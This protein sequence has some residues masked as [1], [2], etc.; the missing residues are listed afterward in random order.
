MENNDNKRRYPKQYDL[1]MATVDDFI[2]NLNENYTVNNNAYSSGHTRNA[3]DHSSIRHR[4][5]LYWH[6]AFQMQQVNAASHNGSQN[7]S[8]FAFQSGN[9]CNQQQMRGRRSN[10]ASCVTTDGR[11]RRE[12]DLVLNSAFSSEVRRTRPSAL[13]PP[14]E[15][16]G[17]DM[18]RSGSSGVSSQ[19]ATGNSNHYIRRPVQYPFCPSR[20]TSTDSIKTHRL[21][22]RV[23]SPLEVYQQFRYISIQTPPLSG[24]YVS[25]ASVS[26]AQQQRRREQQQ[27][28]QRQGQEEFT[29]KPTPQSPPTSYADDLITE[30]ITPPNTLTP[31]S[32]TE[33]NMSDSYSN[34][35][36]TGNQTAEYQNTSVCFQRGLP[37]GQYPAAHAP[38][39]IGFYNGTNLGNHYAGHLGGTMGDLAIPGPSAGAS[40]G[41]VG[42]GISGTNGERPLANQGA[43]AASGLGKAAKRARTAYTSAQL[44]E[45]EKEF[46]YS[47]YLCRP[48]RIDL[49]RTLVLT[50]R[51]IKIWF[52]NR[53][54]KQ[55]K[56]NKAKGVTDESL[57]P[58][59]AHSSRCHSLACRG[60]AHGRQPPR[61]KNTT[62]QIRSQSSSNSTTPFQGNG[63]SVNTTQEAMS[64]L[65]P[66][67]N[68]IHSQHNT[69]YGHQHTGLQHLPHEYSYITPGATTPTEAQYSFPQVPSNEPHHQMT[70]HQQLA[71]QHLHIAQQQQQLQMTHHQHA[72]HHHQQQQQHQ[73]HQMQERGLS[74]YDLIPLPFQFTD[75]MVGG[76]PSPPSDEAPLE[77]NQGPNN[78][79][80][81]R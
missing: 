41:T 74:H 69:Y 43:E 55:K 5:P 53:R 81:K 42:T 68:T 36:T 46:H 72:V 6:R 76:F 30:P 78:D 49:S 4:T 50:E 48:R 64:Q 59:Q 13:T 8:D 56:E 71:Q 37:S 51:Q 23:M 67:N 44:V 61:P 22:S 24:T 1:S 80:G 12:K 11:S 14:E 52:Q 25:A 35:G 27:Q 60:T 45:L 15:N 38:N 39:N 77:Q 28:Q 54:M 29:G 79:R 70:P 33:N 32:P 73:Q 26:H 18:T 40:C 2:D 19:Q 3:C 16:I 34:G 57:T 66:T 75:E 63:Y 10:A 21:D 9:Q 7:Q 31:G 17:L 20:P 65:I 62:D 58:A 47:R